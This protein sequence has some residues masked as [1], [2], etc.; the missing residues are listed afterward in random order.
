MAD[1]QATA[2]RRGTAI[3]YEGIPYRVLE[4]EHRTPGN[5]RGFVQ[6]KLRN[7]LDGT[8]RAV[9]FSAADFVERAIVETREMDYL[10]GEGET[11]VFMDAETYDQIQVGGEIFEEAR[12]W[13]HEGLR[14]M[15]E[16]LDGKPIG[17]RLPK[18]V[19]ITVRE[20][21]PVLKGQTAAKSNK[22]A[23]L[24]NG[25]TLPVPTFINPGDRIRVDPGELR[26]VERAK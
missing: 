4:F 17:I 8:Q 19:E 16:L 20:T 23:T 26:Y 9:K 2:L 6:T 24:E 7:L 14:V 11:A 5:K 10:Y 13:L 1:I 12:P 3:L 18:T 21:E 15:I 25:V 22:P